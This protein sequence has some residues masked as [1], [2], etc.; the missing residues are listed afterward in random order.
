[1]SVLN[2]RI[3]EISIYN[4]FSELIFSSNDVKKGWD[5]IYKGREVPN[6]TYLVK[7]YATDLFGKVYKQTKQIHLIR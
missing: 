7:V 6:G 5:G 1:M 4:R 2:N 3:F